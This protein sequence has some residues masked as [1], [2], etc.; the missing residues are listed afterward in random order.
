[1]FRNSYDKSMSF[2]FLE[3]TCVWICSNG[4]IKSDEMQFKRVHK[5]TADEDAMFSIDEG[6]NRIDIEFNKVKEDMIAFKDCHVDKDTMYDLIGN[7]FFEQAAISSVQLNIIKD[8]LNNSDKF[9]HLV[10]PDFSAYDL[11]NHITESLKRSHPMNYVQDHVATHKL[12]ENRFIHTEE[13]VQLITE[14][15]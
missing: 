6:F 13:P 15:V 14:L 1:M 9:R 11:Y 7:L 8:Q 10:D 3:G 2:A 4:C 12:F 5:G